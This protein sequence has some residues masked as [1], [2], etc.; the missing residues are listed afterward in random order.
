MIKGLTED[1]SK[2]VTHQVTLFNDNKLNGETV[3]YSMQ[4]YFL[5]LLTDEQISKIMKSAEQ[6]G[7][8][9]MMM[10]S[11]KKCQ[12]AVEF[13]MTMGI[14]VELQEIDKTKI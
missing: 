11:K 3:F 4:L 14:P 12:E 1:Q 7:K 2:L 10:S 8:W 6:D 5:T 13:F 9:P